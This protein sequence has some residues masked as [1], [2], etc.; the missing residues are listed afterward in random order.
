M[1]TILVTGGSGFL[2]VALCEALARRGDTVIALDV[3]IGEPLA[4]RAR[5]HPNL[6]PVV[7][8]LT[9]W[10]SLA[11]VFRA[12]RPSSVFHCGAVVG[13][14]ASLACPVTTM[15]ANV[16]GTLNLLECMRLFGSRRVLQVSS[17]E[18]YGDFLTDRIDEEHPR[19]ALL[20]YGISKLA[21]EQLGRSY[22]AR[23]GLECI[24]LRTSWVYGA[25]LPRERVPKSFLTAIVSR[26]RCHVP[27][28]ADS[29][30][31]HTYVD[32]FVAGALAA[33]DHDRHRFDAYHVTSG[34]AVTVREIVDILKGWEPA[35]DI[36]VGQGAYLH[37]P[38]VPAARKGALD[39]SRAR[40]E[41]GYRPRFDIRAG[42]RRCLDQMKSSHAQETGR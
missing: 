31:D 41:L 33:L 24:A 3:R 15:R 18:V 17:E 32:D 40:A 37:G 8:D 35:A 12:H 36:G 2:G 25:E 1:A 20:P 22:A 9:D 10:P 39:V 34:E 26:T 4:A 42:L 13:V 23:F 27:G 30:I 14:I 21:C 16:E 29:L 11:D 19:N 6:A 5:A 28:G 7:A 38:G